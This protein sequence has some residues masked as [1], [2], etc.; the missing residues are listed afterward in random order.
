MSSWKVCISL[1]FQETED[2][3]LM[4]WHRKIIWV[5]LMLIS[6][7]Q[8]KFQTTINRIDYLHAGVNSK[9]TCF[10]VGSDYN[11]SYYNILKMKKEQL[12]GL[13]RGS[14]LLT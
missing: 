8:D 9:L 5:M 12:F 13:V 4:A 2:F 10:L 1:L 11:I 6:L 14:F 7:P 3:V